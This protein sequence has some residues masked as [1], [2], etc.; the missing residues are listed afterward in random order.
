[1]TFVKKP[2]RAAFF[3]KMAVRRFLLDKK[4]AVEYSDVQVMHK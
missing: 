2:L 3:F 1:M 4:T